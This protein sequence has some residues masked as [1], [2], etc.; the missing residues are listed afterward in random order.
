M[1]VY[2][3]TLGCAKNQSDSEDLAG[4]LE[5]AG[6][7]VV[8][9]V[10]DAEV[11]V[12]NTCG[13]IQPAVEECIDAF[14]ELEEL[15]A[16]GRLNKIVVAGCLVNRYGEDLKKEFPSIDFWAFSQEWKEVTNYISEE[17][18]TFT[19]PKN[20]RKGKLPVT[21]WWSR[22]LKISE[23]C[24]RHCSFCTIPSIRGRLR[25][26]PV[27]KIILQ[28]E[29]L[30]KTGAREL[31]I[32]SQDPTM[33][34]TDIA[35]RPLFLELLKDL[36]RSLPENLWIRLNYLNPTGIDK[37]LLEYMASSS[38]ILSY[39]DAPVQHVDQKILRNMNRM[40]SMDEFSKLFLAAREIDPSFALRTTFITGFPGENETQ[41]DR[42][43]EFMEEIKFDWVGA[44]PFYPEDG[45]PA[46]DLKPQ[47]EKRVRELRYQKL[48]SLQAEIS[49][50]RQRM[51][52]GALL[53]ILV[54]D[55]SSDDDFIWGRSFREAPDVDGTVGIQRS[56]RTA[57]LGVGDIIRT[58][59]TDSAEY[60]L[61]AEVVSDDIQ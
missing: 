4:Y 34:G 52:E 3:L 14:L 19:I 12:V 47:T 17:I 27:K 57:S 38:V 13:F 49:L 42:I 21:N 7:N 43:L 45:T 37:N 48:M 5:L 32:V 9:D 24:D 30:V 16:Q 41:F 29:D 39:L 56:E 28:A 8:D 1:D 50:E 2:L 6:C 33:Y 15:K 26:L 11:A 59:I 60:D 51:F 61:F 35:G 55:V 53:D 22:Y 20:V 31:C 58:R 44:F 54:E 36:E 46:A 18:G 25:S 10:S 40:G 23:G